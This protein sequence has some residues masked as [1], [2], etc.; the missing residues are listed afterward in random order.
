MSD[1][2]TEAT[3]RE[4]LDSGAVRA[5]TIVAQGNAWAV[6]VEVGTRWR[7]LRSARDDVR[8][9]KSLDRLARW[10]R[11]DLG[12]A[13]WSVDARQYAPAQRSAA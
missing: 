7:V 1:A 11:G 9:W 13:E 2:I 10:L 12:I 5:V 8:W 4:L 3:L 6:Q